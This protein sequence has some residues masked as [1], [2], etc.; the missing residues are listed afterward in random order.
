MAQ[1]VKNEGLK[2]F[3][4]NILPDENVLIFQEGAQLISVYFGHTDEAIIMDEVGGLI[5][6][7]MGVCMEKVELL[8]AKAYPEGIK[9]TLI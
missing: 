2:I 4:L 9:Q 3:F 8:I 1:E 7:N 5:S 6:D